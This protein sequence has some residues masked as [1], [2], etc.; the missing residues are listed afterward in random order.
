MLRVTVLC[1]DPDH[2]VNAWLDRWLERNRHRAEIAIV[3]DR[4]DCTGGDF[5]FLISCHQ[6]I[7]ADIRARY[8]YTLVIHASDLPKGRGWS[9]MAWEVLNGAD[10]VTVSLLNAEDGVDS[11][12]IWQKRRFAL[13]G[14]ELL[15]ELNAK[16]FETELDLMDWA[17]DHCH[18]TAPEPQRGEPSV[19]PR[20]GPADSEIDPA[21]P[22]AESFDTIRISDPNR[23]PAFFTHRGTTYTI[24]LEK[25]P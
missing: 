15:D 24:R 23:F 25:L 4:A 21:R 6:I 18:E 17:L 10:S 8:G 19:W 22:L 12:D 13:E 14:T 7:G 5:L 3:R 2:P 11:G 20:R 16:L 9:P 1:S